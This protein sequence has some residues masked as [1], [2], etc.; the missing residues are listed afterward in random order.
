MADIFDI[1]SSAS[2]A[3]SVHQKAVKI[4]GNN[5]ANVNT[6]GYSR[7]RLNLSSDIPVNT[8]YGPMGTGVRAV[9]VE[10]IYQRFL[11]VQINNE[12]QSLGQWQAQ[13]GTLERVEMVFDETGGYG[14]NQVMSEFWNAWQDL[15]NNPSGQVQRSVLSAKGEVLASTFNKVYQDLQTGQQEIDAMISES[16]DEIN[17]YS[18]QIADLNLRIIQTESGGYN[19]NE[20]RDQRDLALKELSERIGINSFEEADGGVSVLV[21]SGQTLVQGT[22]QNTISTQANAN[23]LEDVIWVDSSNNIVMLND[24]I[25]GGKLRGWLDTRDQDIRNYLNRLDTISQSLMDEVNTLHAGGYGLDGST[26]IDFFTGSATAG[27]TM[28]SWLTITAEDGG[29]GNVSISLVAGGTAGAEQVTEDPI[30]GE[31]QIAIESGASS[32]ASIAAQLQGHPGIAA[33]V[34]VAPPDPATTLVTLGSGTDAVLLSG[35]L[36]AAGIHV[37][38]AIVNDTNKIA[39]AS[40]FD[41]T[42]GDK[43]G[44]NSNAIAIANLQDAL[45]MSGGTAAFGSYYASLVSDVGHAVVQA[46]SYHGHQSQMVTQLE[47]YRESVSGVS[48]DEEM[49]NLVKFQNAYQAAAKLISTADEMLQ[50]VMNM[51]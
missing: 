46:D 30:T 13:K 2:K 33:A 19:A 14:L 26:T 38:S 37:N 4:T 36:S 24:G 12:T 9:G 51:V 17:R 3:L 47:N 20:Y 25:S 11:G 40:G 6:P 27:G 23:G 34:A 15:T 35:G 31:I 22:H 16:V 32:R 5:I 41:T 29:A 44:D 18:E 28:D 1:M 42:P 45:T 7:Q 10:R 21:G 43:P 49:V 39:A 48:I 50:T 8:G